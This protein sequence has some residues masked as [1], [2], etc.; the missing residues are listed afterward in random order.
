MQDVPNYKIYSA[1]T[2][3]SYDMNSNGLVVTHIL[4]ALWA[5]RRHLSFASKEKTQGSVTVK[6]RGL[7]RFTYPITL[8]IGDQNF[9]FSDTYR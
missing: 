4:L 7:H 1:S 3:T 6:E 5:F 9:F 8:S 2:D